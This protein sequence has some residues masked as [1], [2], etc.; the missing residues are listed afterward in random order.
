LIG[1]TTLVIAHRLSTIRNADKIIVLEKG[2]VVEEGDHET[3]MKTKG[4]YFNL[5]QQQNLR[6]AEEEEKFESEKQEYKVFLS[7]VPNDD[8]NERRCRQTTIVS[9]APSILAALYREINLN[10]DNN[11]D[12]NE[13]KK[14]KV[15]QLVE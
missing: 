7:A 11:Q 14:I 9:L 5:L 2:E 4:T 8:S 3:L 6:Q 1:R 10:A 12:E 15:I 13:G